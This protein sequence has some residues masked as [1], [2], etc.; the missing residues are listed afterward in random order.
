[1]KKIPYNLYIHFDELSVFFNVSANRK[2]NFLRC[3]FVSIELSTYLLG[4]VLNKKEKNNTDKIAYILQGIETQFK[5]LK[6]CDF[7]LETKGFQDSYSENINNLKLLDQSYAG[8]IERIST[9]YFELSKNVKIGLDYQINEIRDHFFLAKLT[10]GN[11]EVSDYV[12]YPNIKRVL[13]LDELEYFNSEDKM[14][15]I[16]HQISECWFNIGV[17]ELKS[18]DKLFQESELCEQKIGHHFKS[19]FETLIYLSEVILLLEHLVLSDYHPLRV[20]LRGASGGQSQQAYEIFSIS[21][22]IFV[23]F[24][25]IIKNDNKN[26]VQILE[27][28]KENY[29]FLSIV[30]HF[31]KLERSLKNFFFQHYVLTSSV[32]GSQS[33]GSIGQDIVSLVDK[34]ID[35]LFKEIDQAKYDLT[36]KT[37]FQYGSISGVLILEKENFISQNIEKHTTN[38]DT[39]NKVIDCYFEEISNFDQ[40]NWIELFAK[41]GYIE[42]PIGSRPY[43]GHQQ[44]SVFF[45]GFLRFFS[46]LNMTI[47]SKQIEKESAKVLWKASATCY[48]GKKVTFSGTEVFQINDN[49]EILIAQVHWDPSVI[50]K[51]L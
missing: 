16:V 18:I 50:A 36:L 47:E 51:Q 24:L 10:A 20:A 1:M 39:I 12:E 41:D 44:L 3:G 43:V 8:V 37:N 11:F 45:K 15:M 46:K 28:P 27:N 25:E 34:F 7:L 33:F 42:D 49:G 31:S 9:L 29:V 19:V 23:K 35:P 2:E 48:N 38:N 21:R 30:N 13:K 40:V 32:I 4:S 5:V 22:K 14:F 6:S 26:I 17:N